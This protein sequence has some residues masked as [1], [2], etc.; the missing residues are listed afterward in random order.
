M[1]GYSVKT[2]KFLDFQSV[3]AASQNLRKSQ[4]SPELV[5]FWVLLRNASP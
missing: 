2:I 5:I 4:T 3:Y 1:S